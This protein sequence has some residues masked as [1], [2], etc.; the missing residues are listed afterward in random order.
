MSPKV[1]YKL[2][3]RNETFYV[4]I[5]R[6]TTSQ[7]VSIFTYF[8]YQKYV[9]PAPIFESMSNFLKNHHKI[10]YKKNKLLHLSKNPNFFDLGFGPK[11]LTPKN[12][13]KSIKAVEK[14]FDLV[15]ITEL[16]EESLLAL[17]NM[18][19]L[20]WD[21]TA[22]FNSND[23]FNR[24]P[25]APEDL[26]REILK[27]NNA[28]YQLYQYFYQKL[29]TYSQ[30]LPREDFENLR[31]YQKFWNETCIGQ[32]VPKLSYDDKFHLGY[33]LKDDIPYHYVGQCKMMTFSEIQ[34]VEKY[35]QNKRT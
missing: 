10:N 24:A 14:R 17:K 15:M 13:Q 20:L 21:E 7:W 11:S 2:F 18:L 35:R 8:N 28:D 33:R 26:K 3:P 4:T 1:N 29:K 16:W 12:L 6:N 34:F 27:Y 30:K 9:P 32:R 22:V 31:K 5:L 19:N 25:A 23:P